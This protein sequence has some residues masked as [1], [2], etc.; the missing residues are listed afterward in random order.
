MTENHFPANAETLNAIVSAMG[1]LAMSVAHVLEPQQ[2]AQMAA[3]IAAIAGQAEA[4][5][6]TTL[7]TLL[8]DMHRAI[9]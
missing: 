9:A 3:A 6:N 1:A 5:G 4:Q 7:E 8:L 2:R